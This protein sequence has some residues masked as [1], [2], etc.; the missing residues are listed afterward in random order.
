MDV[1]DTVSVMRAGRDDSDGQN[2]ETSPEELAE[3]MVGR[4]VLLRVIKSL[5]PAAR[6]LEVRNLNVIDES[7]GANAR[8][9]YLTS[10]REI[11][12][13]CGGG[14]QRAIGTA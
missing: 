1:T 11:L 14:G 13:H 9:M 5:Q 2:A 6:C 10:G 7:R 8:R 3:L 4:K 12:G